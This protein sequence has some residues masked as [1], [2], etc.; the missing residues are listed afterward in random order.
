MAQRLIKTRYPRNIENS[1]LVVLNSIIRKWKKEADRLAKRYIYP[2]VKG[3]QQILKTDAQD[4]MDDVV[5]RLNAMSFGLQN[6]QPDY[7]LN[8]ATQQFVRALN[9]FS[10]NNVKMQTA[11]IGINPVENDKNL[12]NYL[13]GK[14]M[15]NMQ[16]VKNM[17][18]DWRNKIVGDI[19]REVTQ[20]CSIQD[21]A[22][23]IMKRTT[24]A[25]N[26]AKLIANDQTGTIISDL[27]TYRNKQAGAES[28]IWQTMEDDRV[29][30]AH[31]KLD[32]KQF[33]YDDPNGGDDGQLPGQPINCRCVGTPVFD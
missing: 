2:C 17:E 26:H 23:D 18:D 15:E 29:R 19:Y 16:L 10:Y 20:G 8:Q 28:Y 27:N 7:L 30:P 11:I 5:S 1:Y 12:S 13:K 33:D 3:G 4:P 24:M 6:L 31:R 22:A 9:T 21:I 25:Y 32:G 14:V